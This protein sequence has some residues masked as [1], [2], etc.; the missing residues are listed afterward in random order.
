MPLQPVAKLQPAPGGKTVAREKHAHTALSAV[1]EQRQ[2]SLCRAAGACRSEHNERVAR[3][4]DR[5]FRRAHGM[6]HPR[7]QRVGLAEPA[8]ILRKAR[9]VAPQM[10]MRVKKLLFP[11]QKVG[12][13]HTAP[14]IR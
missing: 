2:R 4:A 5:L 9:L 12:Q 11:A 14:D 1:A 6:E 10:Q 7:R 8:E 13:G 3:G